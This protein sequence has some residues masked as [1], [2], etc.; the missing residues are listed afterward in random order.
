MSTLIIVES[1][2]KAHKIQEYLGE[3]YVVMASYGHI[4]DLAKG[5]KHGLGI[6]IEN[7][8]KPK[9]VLMDDK[10]K[11][12]DDL[13]K[14]AQVCDNIMIFSDPDREGESIA[15][16]LA[17]RLE[18]ME[19]PIKRGMFHE[20][21]KSAIQ[22]AVKTPL[23]IDQNL[24]HA[25]EARRILDRLVG[26]T[27]SPYLM[28][29]F[30]T[31]LSAGRVQSCVTRMIVERELAIEQ[32]VPEDFYTLQVSL[33]DG[34]DTFAAKYANKITDKNTAE[35]TKAALS[36]RDYVVSE[37]VAQEEKKYPIPPLVTSTLQRIMSK[38]HGFSADRTMKAAQSL[39]ENGYCTYIRTDSVRVGDEAL[40]EVRQWIGAKYPLPK[41]PYAYKN[42][43]SAQ[44]AHE[45]IRPVE[46]SRETLADDDYTTVDLDQKLV[47]Q[48][49]WQYFLASQM[50]PAV[51]NTLAITAHP[52][53]DKKIKVKASGK[54]I[55][56][57]GFL[58]VLGVDDKSSIDIPN[59][60]VGQKLT[61]ANVK[62]PVR[63][64]KK[65]T[66]P[67]P[68]YSED[69]L[70]KELD[71][72]KIGRPSTYAELLNKLT[73][74]NYVEKVGNVFHATD[75]GKKITDVLVSNFTFLDYDF[76]AKL[77]GLLDNIAEGKANYIDVLKDFWKVYSEELFKSYAANDKD[78][79]SCEKCHSPM[80]KRNGKFGVF[81][82][83]VNPACKNIRNEK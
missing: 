34:T 14:A 60:T 36:N 42:K 1:P 29:M 23:E 73:T 55:K 58:D 4:A 30:N 17:K 33:T 32:F 53:N 64:E 48:T 18:D 6:D 11:V 37:V 46:I 70:I 43:E 82:S 39:Y 15:W 3:D 54:A 13:M 9:Y 83:C 49:I 62:P 21:K 51:Y 75:L 24:F 2:A 25:Q 41:K 19:K 81:F 79:V 59:L 80:V 66:Q 12:L 20:I 35:K 45:C 63:L 44:D 40:E 50:M 77:E 76:T 31:N 65:Q 7:N 26:F 16:H 8:F 56:D 74:R 71:D 10:V 68:R 52:A 67:P 22:K 27:A 28:N 38:K 5:G 78:G 57:K 47:Y 61:L 69:K 72:R